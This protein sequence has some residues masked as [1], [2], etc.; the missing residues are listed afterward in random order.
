[1]KK[2]FSAG[3]AAI[4]LAA[5][6]IFPATGV[7]AATIQSTDYTGNPITLR[8]SVTGVTNPVTNTFGYT[9]QK[10][11]TPSGGDVSGFPTS[12]SIVM[13]G[14]APTGTTA[15]ATTTVDFSAAN[16]TAVG[17]YT[18]TIS[19]SSTT[20]V[21]NYPI[22]TDSN[23]YIATVQVRYPVDST[24]GVPDNSKMI[25]TIVIH[26]KSENKVSEATWTSGAARTHIQASAVTTGN[27]ADKSEC[28]AYTISIPVGNGVVAGDT[29]AISSS[30]TCSGS[31]TSVTAGTPAT[32]Y[33]KHG[34]S[35]LVGSNN[36]ANQ[37][38]IGASY[39][40]TKTN[41]GDDYIEKIDGTAGS[42][43]TKTA[44][45]PEDP[46]FDT[47]NI[48]AFE[49]NKNADPLT[50]IVTNFWF[51][52]MLIVAGLVGFFII[53]RRSKQDDEQQQ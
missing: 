10:G 49:N 44:V 37:I 50:G 14:T 30:T 51:Y 25:A 46:T 27:M 41:A 39:T 45:D 18:F 36:G 2:L 26:N 32:V 38:P 52:V 35:V 40:W 12:A 43:I 1:M 3:V 53:S 8:R 24:T 5:T 16:Y 11:T 19:E 48:T 22:D 21:A 47:K 7:F 23:N 20:D 13:N 28:F 4:A 17:D 42:T 15:T 9:I 31:A 34:D 33:L 29:F 6:A